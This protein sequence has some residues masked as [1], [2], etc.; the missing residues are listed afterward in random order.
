MSIPALD[1]LL[2]PRKLLHPS[3]PPAS[4]LLIDILSKFPSISLLSDRVAILYVMFIVMSWLVCPCAEC[5]D[6]LPH[7]A[8]PIEEQHSRTHNA[9]VDYIPWPFMRKQFCNR[10]RAL[11][12]LRE[13]FLPYTQR[14]SVNWAS[15]RRLRLAPHSLRPDA[16]AALA[17]LTN[18]PPLS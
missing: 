15:S 7:W 11:P 9:Y 5:F 14:L 17:V 6:R 8:K 12:P 10:G 4:A 3:C 16:N 18:S 1:A 13:F 2:D